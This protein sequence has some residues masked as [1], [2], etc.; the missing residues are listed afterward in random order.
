MKEAPTSFSIT[1]E[2]PL[3][4]VFKALR[5]MKIGKAIVHADL[6][7]IARRKKIGVSK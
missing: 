5:M 3:K 1:F 6:F 7:L 4:V 2:L